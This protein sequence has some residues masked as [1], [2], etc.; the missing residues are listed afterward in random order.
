MVR[1]RDDVWFLRR[2]ENRYRKLVFPA[3]VV[4]DVVCEQECEEGHGKIVDKWAGVDE[5]LAEGVDVLCHVDVVE[6]AFCS[7]VVAHNHGDET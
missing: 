3:S 7:K 6:H 2:H 1:I 4:Y 5:A